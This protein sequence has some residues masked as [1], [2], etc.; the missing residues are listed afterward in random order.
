MTGFMARIVS[1]FLGASI[2]F[3]S[4]AAGAAEN[5]AIILDY[6]GT[7]DPLLQSYNELP[8]GTTIE[9]GPTEQIILLHYKTCR[10]IT[11]QGGKIRVGT[12]DLDVDGGKMTVTES[13]TCP[14][15]SQLRVAGIGG[16]V[17][18]RAAGPIILPDTLSCILVGGKGGDV[19]SLALVD[20]GKTVTTAMVVGRRTIM[21]PGSL[22]IEPGHA[23][24]LR[25]KLKGIE[26]PQEQKISTAA[27]PL[28]GPCLI[29]LD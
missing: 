13:G 18:V 27:H 15:Q 28:S 20:G 24:T 8:S 4:P 19:E 21:M 14:Q 11:I 1:L 6:T 9:L 5:A 3:A 2:A 22:P 29:R 26:E 10:T 17:M 25:I 23:Y 16:G 7:P 12:A